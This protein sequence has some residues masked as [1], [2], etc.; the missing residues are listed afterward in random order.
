MVAQIQNRLHKHGTNVT[1]TRLWL[2]VRQVTRNGVW[3][4]PEAR[5]QGKQETAQTAGTNN[6]YECYRLSNARI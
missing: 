1:G 4:V 6:Y 5:G 3:R 2:A